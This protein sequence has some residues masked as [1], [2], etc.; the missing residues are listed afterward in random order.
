MD[1]VRPQSF[2]IHTSHSNVETTGNGTG[3]EVVSGPKEEEQLAEA[4]FN[5]I[6]IVL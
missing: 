2:F 5:C 4:R 3:I 1:G 6:Y